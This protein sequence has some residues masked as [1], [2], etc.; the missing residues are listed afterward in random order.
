MHAS[1]S[2]FPVPPSLDPSPTP[3]LTSL[4]GLGSWYVHVCARRKVPPNKMC[5]VCVF[6]SDIDECRTMFGVCENGRCINTP[7]SF[8]C[9]CQRGYELTANQNCIGQHFE[10]N[11]DPTNKYAYKSFYSCAHDRLQIPWFPFALGFVSVFFIPFDL[12]IFSQ[13]GSQYIHP[14][15]PLSLMCRYWRVSSRAGCLPQWAVS[16]R[17]GLLHLSVQ[18][19]LPPL[20]HEGRVCW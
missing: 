10:P 9:Q 17:G 1:P 5:H 16:E 7:G 14:H 19:R 3:H 11:K 15:Y 4:F 20:S 8:T 13:R 6:V 12:W 18:R 2:P